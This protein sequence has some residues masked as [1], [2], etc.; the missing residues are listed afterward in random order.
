MHWLPVLTHDGRL[1]FIVYRRAQRADLHA[2]GEQSGLRWRKS[3]RNARVCDLPERG[4]GTVRRFGRRATARHGGA[5]RQP[6]PLSVPGPQVRS[7]VPLD[8][9]AGQ[10]RRLV[11]P[12]D[13]ARRVHMLAS[14]RRQQPRQM[15][16]SIAWHGGSAVVVPESMA[17]GGDDDTS[18]AFN[19]EGPAPMVPIACTA[20]PR[21]PPS[22]AG[23]HSCRSGT[24][25]F[26]AAVAS[27]RQL[28]GFSIW[29][30]ASRRQVRWIGCQAAT[31][32]SRSHPASCR[33]SAAVGTARPLVLRHASN[34]T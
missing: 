24:L 15:Q 8:A 17:H 19:V 10:S 30:T 5:M 16:R 25:G 34:G 1:I 9:L 32:C 31:R 28:P 12:N 27:D 18:D 33:P 2:N 6:W 21:S 20:K 22:Y 3:G 13:H 7:D 26:V 11:A 29:M 4:E 23:S 14:L